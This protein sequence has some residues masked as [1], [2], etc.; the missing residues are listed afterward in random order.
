MVSFTYALADSIE[1]LRLLAKLLD[2]GL[3]NDPI[4]A[5][6]YGRVPKRHHVHPDRF[7]RI[8]PDDRPLLD[9]FPRSYY[10]GNI[11][12]YEVSK[13]IQEIR[14]RGGET[15]AE[16]YA[17]M[18]TPNT[19]LGRSAS[20]FEHGDRVRARR[21]AC[22]ANLKNNPGLWLGSEQPQA[23]AGNVEK[24]I[25]DELF[26]PTR[27]HLPD[28]CLH[29]LEIPVAVNSLD[30][31]QH[32]ELHVEYLNKEIWRRRIELTRAQSKNG[33]VIRECPD[34]L[35][36]PPGWYRD[37]EHPSGRVTKAGS[38][39]PGSHEAFYEA[40]APSERRANRAALL[41]TSILTLAESDPS[42][43]P[44][45]F[46]DAFADNK[47]IFQTCLASLDSAVSA[48]G[49]NPAL[50]YL[51]GRF[52]DVLQKRDKAAREHVPNHFSEDVI[53]EEIW[54]ETEDVKP[55]AAQKDDTF[56][57]EEQDSQVNKNV[58]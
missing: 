45:T 51:L 43:L 24:L 44:P 10:R 17:E 2:F 38:E 42:T 50:A 54:A 47:E 29:S 49:C 21:E 8:P 34:H 9:D 37:I 36:P 58:W 11:G 32:D 22:L 14:N 40:D 39:L 55:V 4:K 13:L 19:Y 25:H 15:H 5:E 26:D 30:G 52:M 56:V 27:F 7:S 6:W 18:F 28:V 20:F 12:Q 1:L 23:L 16:T 46:E 48:D 3:H 53:E 31:V 41:I 57:Q 35:L 33:P